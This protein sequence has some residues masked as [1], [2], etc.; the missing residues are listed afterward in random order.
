MKYIH[1]EM[2][3]KGVTLTLLWEEYKE[4]HPDGFMFTQFCKRYRDFRKQ[5][6][7]YMHKVYKAGERVMIDWA[8]LT[9]SYTDKYEVTHIVYIFV[10]T[11]PASSYMYVVTI[12][13][14][15]GAFVDYCSCKRIRVFPRHTKN[16]D[17]GSYPYRHN[18]FKLLRPKR[19]PNI[20]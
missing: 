14:Y 11:L 9:M 8:G 13:G 4:E 12:H 3:R 10:A 20:R 1:R 16:S 5:N 6:N 2:Q 7:V 17:A 18:K 19:K 15:A